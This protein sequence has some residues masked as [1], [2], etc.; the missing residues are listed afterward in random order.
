MEI[1]MEFTEEID[2]AEKYV[3][4]SCVQCVQRFLPV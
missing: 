2:E 1:Q 3:E 4:R